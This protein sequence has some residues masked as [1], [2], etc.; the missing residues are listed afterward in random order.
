MLEQLVSHCCWFP[1]MQRCSLHHTNVSNL[2]RSQVTPA[3]VSSDAC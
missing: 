1:T 2:L 3:Q